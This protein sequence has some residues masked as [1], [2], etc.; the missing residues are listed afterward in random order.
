MRQC[1]SCWRRGLSYQK[2]HSQDFFSSLFLV[3]KKNGNLH[4]VINLFTL[5]RHLVVIH[6]QMETAQTVRAVIQ[7][8]EWAVLIGIRATYQHVPMSQS[9]CNVLQFVINHQT[10]QFTC[11]PLGLATSPWEFTKLLHPVVQLLRL[12]GTHLHVYLDDW[13]IW[14]GS[15][16]QVS[17]SMQLVIWV[18]H[19]LGWLIK[20]ELIST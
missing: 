16:A 18:L 9:V 2:S 19:H 1:T 17:F 11:L 14:A 6:F 20:A 15:P 8:Q 13:L 4:I 3:L 5:N 7:P 10:Y 12:R